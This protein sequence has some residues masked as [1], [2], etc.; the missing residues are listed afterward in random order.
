[1]KDKVS[2]LKIYGGLEVNKLAGNL[3]DTAPVAEDNDYKKLKGKL[4]S[5]FLPKKNKHQARYTLCKQRPEGGVSVVTTLHN[6]ARNRK[7]ANSESKSTT[8]YWN[9]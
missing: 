3:P 2:A 1:M 7:I 4:D 6:C 9:T 8:G 5:H